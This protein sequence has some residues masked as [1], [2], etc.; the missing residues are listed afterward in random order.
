MNISK[1]AVIMDV[2]EYNSTIMY[3]KLFLR[4]IS[5]Q[6]ESHRKQQWHKAVS[7]RNGFIKQFQQT[8]QDP[9]HVLSIAKH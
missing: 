9:I 4:Q 8:P 5:R 3:D 1:L 7:S 2:T 6:R